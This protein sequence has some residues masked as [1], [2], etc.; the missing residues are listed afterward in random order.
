MCECRQMPDETYI[1][2]DKHSLLTLAALLLNSRQ[3]RCIIL[4]KLPS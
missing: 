4:R 2:L 3:P 1:L